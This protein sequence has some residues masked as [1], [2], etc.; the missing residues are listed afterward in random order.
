M[1]VLIAPDKFKGTL[2]ATQVAR[3]IRAAVARVEPK[4]KTTLCPLSDGGEGFVD[5]L[6]DATDGL[7]RWVSTV[8]ATGQPK[9][10]A[11]GILGDNRTVVIGLTEA[12]A[13]ADV[14]KDKRNPLHTSNEGT[15]QLIRH[16]VDKGYRRLIVGLGGSATTEGGIGLAA[17]LG[18]RFLDAKGRDIPLTGAGLGKLERIEPPETKLPRLNVTV[19]VDVTNPLYGRRGAA[20]VFAGQKGATVRQVARLDENLRRLAAVYERFAGHAPHQRPGAGAAGGCGFGLMAFLGATPEPGFE[21]V[22]RAI[23][24]EKLIRRHDLVITGEGAL[25]AT[26]LHGKAPV[27]IGRWCRELGKPCW[28]LAGK[29]DLAQKR[30]PFN[31]ARGIVDGSAGSPSVDEALA[32]PRLWLERT[33]AAAIRAWSPQ[34]K[35]IFPLMKQ[36][37]LFAGQGAQTVGMGQDLAGAIP[38]I[39]TFYEKA[40][41]ELD[42]PLSKVC[43]EG[44]E[45][46]LTKTSFCQPALYVHG[47]ALFSL[48]QTQISGFTFD[49]TAGLSLGEFTAHAAAG[50]FDF[51]T[52]LQLVYER[53]RLMQEAVEATEGGM[54]ALI[55]AN[56]EQAVAIA[57]EADVDAANFNA[58]GQIVLSGAAANMPKVVEAAKAAGIKRA[59]PL[60][61]AG[62][63]HS[64][65]MQSAQD[66]LKP[67][68]D[69]ASIN[70]P[71][72]PVTVMSNVL[73][74]PVEPDGIRDVLLRQVTG[75]VRWEACIRAM[76]GQGIERFIEL[77]PGGQLAGMIKRI[78]ANVPCI[79]IGT[80]AEFE[81][82]KNELA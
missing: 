55:G 14:P 76:L 30:L 72:R 53:G 58:P 36:A 78:D 13:L 31:A 22:S 70:A 28:A 42:L 26:S 60:K 20:F 57:K 18:W 45:E 61:V 66:G 2:T 56:E 9:R 27:R 17:G 35:P 50:S 74:G 4:W 3:A 40:D 64:R 75:S 25:D 38:A 48:C 15:G 80:L 71:R 8:D 52:G 46:E 7:K 1:R 19:A 34:L 12:S 67:F 10:A 33:A 24:L 21:I 68:L 29:L 16:A 73:G 47:Y 37:V 44:P 6:V 23:K 43:F 69:E 32:K 63:Y 62:A 41:R 65:L 81:E 59:I 39:K 82:K 5:S 77:G 11:Y 79:S 54:V 49:A 51:M